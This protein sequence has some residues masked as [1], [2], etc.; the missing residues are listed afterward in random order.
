[1]AISFRFGGGSGVNSVAPNGVTTGY[2]PIGTNNTLSQSNTQYADNYGFGNAG[3]QAYNP[4]VAPPSTW[5]APTFSNSMSPES[6]NQLAASRRAAQGSQVAG[7]TNSLFA[8][9]GSGGGGS[10]SGWDPSP[11]A[12]DFDKYSAVNPRG[13]TVSDI[14]SNA[15]GQAYS[16]G[17]GTNVANASLWPNPGVDLYSQPGYTGYKDALL[18]GIFTAEG[19][20]GN[21]G[22]NPYQMTPGAVRQVNST[23]ANVQTDSSGQPANPDESRN[24]ASAL[25]DSFA[26]KYP[27]AAQLATAYNQGEGNVNRNYNPD[28]AG[29]TPYKS[30]VPQG[31][32]VTPQRYLQGNPAVGYSGS[33]TPM[34]QAAASNQV[35]RAGGIGGTVSGLWGGGRG[36]Q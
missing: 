12:S 26:S 6:W 3:I 29:S 10:S 28:V 8:S 11:Q 14:L 36:G 17:R 16:G 33:M 2:V 34:T 22:N 9:L 23:G 4:D 35:Q 7:G 20:P 32:N 31:V 18:S 24:G 5:S 21:K 1:M 30:N 27:Y 13:S 19:G 25:L 15:A